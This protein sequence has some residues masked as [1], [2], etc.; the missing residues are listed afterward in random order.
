MYKGLYLFC[1]L[2]LTLLYYIVLYFLKQREVKRKAYIFGTLCIFVCSTFAS[3]P[4]HR[5]KSMK[6]Q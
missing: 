1:K 3:K 6:G 5:F 4:L 2:E